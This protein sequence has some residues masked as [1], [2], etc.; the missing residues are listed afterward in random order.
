MLKVNGSLPINQGFTTWWLLFTM[1]TGV[2]L[3]MVVK[4]WFTTPDIIAST[5]RRGIARYVVRASRSTARGAMASFH[6]ARLRLGARLRCAAAYS[7]GGAL[8]FLPATRTA[9]F[10]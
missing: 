4:C 8:N 7:S 5:E 1:S 9:F 10:N 6:H 2:V 3:A